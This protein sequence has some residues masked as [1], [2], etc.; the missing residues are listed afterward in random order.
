M[1][2]VLIIIIIRFPIHL[3][4]NLPGIQRSIWE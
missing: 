4:I 1:F 3:P 2:T